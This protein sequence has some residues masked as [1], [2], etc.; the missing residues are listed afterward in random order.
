VARLGF[1]R[2]SPRYQHRVRPESREE[3]GVGAFTNRAGRR[4][5]PAILRNVTP[6]SLFSLASFV[7]LPGWLLLV[8]VP[9]WRWSA[10][11]VSSLVI[12]CLLGALYALILVPRFGGAQGGFGS[13]ADVRKL[14]EDPY[15]LLAGWL[16]YL[17]FDLFIGAWEVRDAQRSGMPHLLVVPCLFL[18]FMFGPIG[19]L[20]YVVIRGV[21]TRRIAIDETS[22]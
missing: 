6:D 2:A 7:V 4:L 10:R 3:E 13:L 12:P 11:L 8:F 22:A 15:L 16:H 14:F 17:A 20:L 9:R 1:L 5:T 19:L 21:R 18:T